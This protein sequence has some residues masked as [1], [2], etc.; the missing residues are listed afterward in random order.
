MAITLMT[1]YDVGRIKNIEKDISN[2]K[3]GIIR[4][5]ISLDTEL[6][7]YSINESEALRNLTTVSIAKREIQLV[8]EISMIVLFLWNRV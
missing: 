2:V 7:E 4:F 6:V 1:Q 3:K 8:R 5:D